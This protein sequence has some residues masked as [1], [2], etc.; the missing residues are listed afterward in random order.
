MFLNFPLDASLQ[1]FSGMDI[2]PYRNKLSKVFPGSEFIKQ[3]RLI[4]K[5][6]RNW[7]GFKPSPELACRFYYFAEEF[8]RGNEKFPCNP[9]RWDKIILNLIGSKDYDPS[10]HSVMKWNDIANRIAG[11]IKA[12]VDHLRALGWSLEHAW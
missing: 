8:I 11:D 9:L 6:T 1:K 5:N 10:L 7:M 3:K 2:T 12:Y 4:V